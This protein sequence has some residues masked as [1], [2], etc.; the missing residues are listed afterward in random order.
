MSKPKETESSFFAWLLK[1]L[2]E[3]KPEEVQ[4]LLDNSTGKLFLIAWSL[5]ESRCFQTEF[6]VR[7]IKDFSENVRADGAFQPKEIW[8][9]AEHFHDRYQDDEKLDKLLNN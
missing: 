3:S 6:N 4:R 8:D 2:D 5:F 7:K 9:A 1:L